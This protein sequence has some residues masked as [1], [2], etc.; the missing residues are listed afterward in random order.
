[1]G[2][3]WNLDTCNGEPQ[4]F[5]NWPAEFGKIFRGKLGPNDVAVYKLCSRNWQC[6]DC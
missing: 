1:V 6:A 3:S 5:A 4:T 2:K